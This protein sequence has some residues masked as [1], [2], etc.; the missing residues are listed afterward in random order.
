MP[1]DILVPARAWAD[2]SAHDTAARKLAALF[3]EKQPEL[4]MEA[5]FRIANVALQVVKGMNPLYAE[6]KLAEREEIVR[7]FK[8][9]LTSYLSSRLVKELA[10]LGGP[11]KDFV[12]PIVHERL[13]AKFK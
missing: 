5:A 8:L 3:R 7:E 2:P 13:G 6:A 11:I 4:T 1:G 12:P 9:L 10:R